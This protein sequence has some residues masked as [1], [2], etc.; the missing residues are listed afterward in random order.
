M[1]PSTDLVPPSINHYRPVLIQ[2]QQVPTS[3]APYW[4][5][6]I[7]YQPVLLH[8]DPVPPS[9][10]QYQPILTQYHLVLTSTAFYW[11]STTKYQPLPPF[12]DPVPSY[13]PVPLYTDPLPP[14]SSQYQ[15]ILLLLGN[16]RLLHSLPRVLFLALYANL[17]FFFIRPIRAYLKPTGATLC[18]T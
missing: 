11:P 8:T 9:I 17:T 5:S 16:Y 14:S 13:Q 1:S 3:V 18:P 15:P 2:Y 12:T 10:N 4:P 6:M 7:I